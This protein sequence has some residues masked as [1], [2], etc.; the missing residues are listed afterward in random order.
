MLKNII[1]DIGYQKE[2]LKLS[3]N[4]LEI[5]HISKN[6]GDTKVLKDI[7]I[8]IEKKQ[9]VVLLGPS[10][11]GKT[12][13][14]RIISGLTPM[15]S[16][17]IILNG[18]N[19]NKLSV[20]DRQIGFVFQHY[21]LF[22]HMNVFDNIAFGLKLQK[23]KSSEIKEKV[24]ATMDLVELNGFENRKI[25]ELSGGQ[26]QRVALA[27]ALVIEPELLLLDEPLSNLDAKLRASVRISIVKLQKKL[28][29]T[30]IMVTHDQ[31]EAMTMGDKVIMMNDGLIQQNSIPKEMYDNP[32]GKFVAEFLGTPKINIIP[33]LWS[34]T[35]VV[36]GKS[37]IKVEKIKN[38]F[39]GAFNNAIIGSYQVGIRPEHFILS[40]EKNG[41]PAIIN[42][43]EICGPDI[44]LYLDLFENDIVMRVPTCNFNCKIGD[45][46][47]IDFF[48]NSL[49]LFDKEGL[50]VI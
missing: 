1:F 26:Q 11:C 24:L 29:V 48:N 23:I 44:N 33:S 27:R 25:Q 22:P 6:F 18:T 2:E 39:S 34:E 40:D 49:F 35:E 5:K 13:L 19:I 31:I 46:I 37:L 15:T 30:A 17:D 16:G 41:Y 7:N 10:G 8:D 36:L 3:N 43:I 4:F 47:Y 38:K 50:R 12:T 9:F 20:Y 21:A 45:E 42:Y 14:L 32:N 28:G